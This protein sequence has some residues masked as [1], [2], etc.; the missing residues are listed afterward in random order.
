MKGGVERARSPCIAGF[1]GAFTGQVSGAFSIS[2]NV[3]KRAAGATH[4]QIVEN[5]T[6]NLDP[7]R[8][9]QANAILYSL[10]EIESYEEA[11]TYFSELKMTSPSHLI[12]G[13]LSG[14]QGIVISR[15]ADEVSHLY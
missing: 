7:S 5:L 10:L 1:Y 14:I 6:N 9:N 15:T 12:I 13:G 2:Y 4:D 3:R 8:T 11:V